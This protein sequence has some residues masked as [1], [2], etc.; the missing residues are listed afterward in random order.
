NLAVSGDYTLITNGESSA[1]SSGSL[2]LTIDRAKV[3]SSLSDFPVL[4]HLGSSSGTNS[5]DTSAVFTALGSDANRKKISVTTASGTELYVEIE[6]WDTASKE[7]WLWVK[8]PSISSSQDTV[9]YLN[10]DQNRGDNI[11]YV[12]D[13][14]STPAQNVWDSGFKAVYHM[15]DVGSTVK[16][17]TRNAHDGTKVG[18]A[19]DPVMGK[20]GP[21]A[22][23]TGSNYINIPDHDDFSLVET[24]HLLVSSWF[25]PSDLVMSSSRSDGQ[26]RFLSKSANNNHEW[27]MNY[28][29]DGSTR[30]QGIAA[31]F[32]NLDGGLGTGHYMWPY[33]DTRNEI[34]VNEWEHLMGRGDE[35]PAVINGYTRSHWVSTYKNG[36]YRNGQNMD[37]TAT[38]NPQNGNAPVTMGH[39]LSFDSWLE[40]RLDEVRID[41]A[42]R[43]D[44]WIKAS[45]YSDADNLIAISSTT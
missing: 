12:G 35:D 22:L 23:F 9:L 25:S 40:G 20:V 13:I 44:A 41:S 1:G 39:S 37:N 36:V 14:G 8:V 38:I 3:S 18:G 4:V 10:Y 5:A 11:V 30:D 32:F 17:S 31:Y 42:P 7:A 21:S 34:E 29:N 33:G 2:K 43:S 16:D 27:C 6:K 24:R 19:P 45:H 26:I 15:N 28:Y